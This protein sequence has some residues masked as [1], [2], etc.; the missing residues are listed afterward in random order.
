MLLQEL[1][2]RGCVRVTGPGVEAVLEG[3]NQ[4]RA[5]DVSQCKNLV[6]WLAYGYHRPHGDKIR[7]ATVLR[8]G[9]LVR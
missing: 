8:N 4:L 7:F 3:C 6:P 1:S 5:L 2:V 9:R